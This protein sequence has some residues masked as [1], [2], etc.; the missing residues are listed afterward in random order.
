MNGGGAKREGNTESEAG[1]RLWAGST[2]PDLGLISVNR[3]IM[4]WA[5]VGRL[6]NWATQAP[7]WSP[8]LKEKS[9]EN[10]PEQRQPW[11]YMDFSKSEYVIIWLT[12]YN[13]QHFMVANYIVT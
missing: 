3:E 8:D 2:E 9:A 13:L 12:N 11:A 4:T 1:S 10:G 6:T 7:P 5:K